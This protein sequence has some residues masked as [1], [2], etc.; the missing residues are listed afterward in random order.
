MH[1]GS[2]TQMSTPSLLSSCEVNIHKY[3]HNSKVACLFRV[4]VY[5]LHRNGVQERSQ[6]ADDHV[7]Q[8]T[9]CEGTERCLVR[10]FYKHVDDIKATLLHDI[11]NRVGND[12]I[13]W[14]E[15]TK[16]CDPVQSSHAVAL[17]NRGALKQVEIHRVRTA[18][19]VDVA[20]HP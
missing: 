17:K 9:P 3:F 2:P 1:S 12:R 16:T 5:N 19:L 7:V 18:L 10:P 14:E 6:I 4:W 13:Q 20:S 11:F 15:A 8:V